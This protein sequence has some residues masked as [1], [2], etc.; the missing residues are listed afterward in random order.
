[1]SENKPK[2]FR[3]IMEWSSWLSKNHLN[4]KTIW[5]VIQ[6]KASKKPG[7]RYEEAVIEAVAHG[8]IDGK[9]RRL[10]DDE[11]YNILLPEK[12][13]AYGPLVTVNEP[14]G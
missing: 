7:I 10:N 11:L 5:I 4:E 2:H 6:K 9:M 3:T 14:S 8:W 1:M 12:A 13:T